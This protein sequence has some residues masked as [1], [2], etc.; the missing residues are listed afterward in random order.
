M[1][2]TLTARRLLSAGVLT[3]GLAGNALA[4]DEC[5][6]NLSE[7]L[8]DFGQMNRLA[9]HDSDAQRLLG[10]RR[11]SLSLSCPQ[12]LDPSLFY[13]ALAANAQRFRF[14]DHGSYE[15]QVSDA[16]LDGKPV[17]LGLLPGVGQAPAASAATLNW[18]PEHAIAPVQNGAVL[19]G[20][21]FSVQLLVKAWA[22]IAA[23][24]VREATTWDVSGQFEARR[25]ERYRQL[26]LRARFVPVACT[27]QL[28]SGGIVDY[29]TLSAKSLNATS[30]TALAAKSLLFSINCDAPAR[31]ALVM[32]D[33]RDGTATGGIDGTAYGLNLDASRNK[34]GRY[35][36]TIDPADFT[37]DTVAQLYRTD[38]TSN[39]AAW[40]SASGR[41]IAMAANS[42]LGFTDS[43]GITTG[44]VAIQ[45]LAGTVRIRTYLAPTQ[46]LDLSDVVSIDGAGTLEI[47]Y[48]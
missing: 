21:H 15:I 8:L 9:Q 46:E 42:Y 18:R 41:Q 40:S 43:I 5:Q 12:A 17:E 36:L 35:Y 10:E 6:L 44:P 26:S 20:K 19:S 29:G 30:E 23:T 24:H 22:D 34:I 31:F 48:Q 11:V 3:L 16:I 14:T 37:A 38:S 2:Y 13:T 32:H 7:A 33:N 28:S 45:N 39:G 27:P 47:F 4:L 1:L 25:A